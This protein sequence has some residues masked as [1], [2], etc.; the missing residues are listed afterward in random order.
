MPP[1]VEFPRWQ[2]DDAW[3]LYHSGTGATIRLS[4]AALAVLDL[5]AESDRLDR[6]AIQH[7]LSAMMDA[8]PAEPEMQASVSE[9]LRVLLNH[10]CIEQV[11]CD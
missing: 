8:P 2:G 10:E 3:V 4:D 6:S 7:A 9:L 1:G 5:F 11:S